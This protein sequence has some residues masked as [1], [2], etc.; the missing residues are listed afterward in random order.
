MKK[1]LLVTAFVFIAALAGIYIF[2]HRRNGAPGGQL[3]GQIA[4]F[5]FI[6]TIPLRSQKR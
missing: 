6:K 2:I 5:S 3:P 4:T 1:W